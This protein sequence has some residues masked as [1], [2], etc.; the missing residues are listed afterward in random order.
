MYIIFIWLFFKK[1]RDYLPMVSKWIMDQQ[2]NGSTIIQF[3][4]IKKL[5]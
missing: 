3:F 1:T 2:M 5:V 4:L